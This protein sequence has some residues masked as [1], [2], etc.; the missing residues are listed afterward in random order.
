[1]SDYSQQ[2]QFAAGVLI[3]T[4]IDGSGVAQPRRFGILQDVQ[5]D[6]SVDLKM[7]YGQNRFAIAEAAG[8]TKVEIKAKWAAIAAG[9]FNDLFFG[10]TQ[11]ATQ[12]KFANNESMTVPGSVAYTVAGA[13]AGFISDEGVYYQNTGLPLTAV[14]T[15]AGA[16]EY[17][18]PS[19]TAGIWTFDSA[20]ANALLLTSYTYSTS[21]GAQISI[22][23]PVMGSS[24]T[25]K[26]VLSNPYDG[27]QGTYT[28]NSCRASK[29]SLP[30]KQDDFEISELDFSA[31]AD[32]AG[33]IGT[34]NYDL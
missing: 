22:A 23:N 1:M 7:L 12:T 13:N 11:T 29:L 9:L 32:S 26:M 6:I 3:G 17:V 25:F 31:T 30:F 21:G 24:P 8:K 15:V 10:A 34:I 14:G 2:I 20:D 19:S 18:P 33:N 27:R 5:I 4:R 16:G 28:F